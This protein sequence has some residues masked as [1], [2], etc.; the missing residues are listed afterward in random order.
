MSKE[1]LEVY[2]NLLDKIKQ[3][4]EEAKATASAILETA[5]AAYFTKYSDYVH[6]VTWTQDI[7]SFNDGE[8]CYFSADEPHVNLAIGDSEDVDI[9]DEDSLHVWSDTT[10]QYVTK[11]LESM[12][13]YEADPL[14]WSR[15][16]VAEESYYYKNRSE[17]YYVRNPPHF[18][19]TV[20]E[21]RHTLD[22]LHNLPDSFGEDTTAL[23]NFISSIDDDTKEALF[24]VGARIILNKQGVSVE[25]WSCG[26]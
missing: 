10:L 6:S 12:L 9:D 23:L 26:Y 24:G 15:A 5:T 7:P 14:A 2:N 3:V 21:L 20:E 4:K 16:K 11:E 1:L 13:A 17:D 22:L 18:Y 25:E 19:N 8:A